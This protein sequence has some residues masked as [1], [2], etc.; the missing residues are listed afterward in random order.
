[1]LERPESLRTSSDLMCVVQL[2]YTNPHKGNLFRHSVSEKERVIAREVLGRSVKKHGSLE[3]ALARIKGTPTMHAVES[4]DTVALG[5][6][7]SSALLLGRGDGTVEAIDV[8]T[9]MPL[10]RTRLHSGRVAKISLN[11]EGRRTVTTS[12]DGSIALWRLN[13]AG[14]A[15]EARLYA[16]PDGEWL[17]ITPAGFFA[18]SSFG[19]HHINVVQGLKAIS[20]AQ[21]FD[22]LYRP[23]LVEELLKGDLEGKYKDAA[24]QLNLDAVLASGPSPQIEHLSDLDDRAGDSIRLSLRITGRGGGVGK[25]IIWKVNGVAQGNTTPPA[26]AGLDGPL[27]SVV[28]TE[29]L[30]LVPGQVNDIEVTAYNGTRLVATPPFK[31]IVDKFGISTTER[32]R[33]FVLA[34]G[35]NKYRMKEYQ[36]SYAASDATSLAKALSMV[37]SSLFSKVTTKAL[38]DEQVSEAG[39]AGAIDQIARE[40]KPEDVF[41][42]FLGGHGKS[43]AGRYYCYPQTLDFA[44]GQAVEQHAIGQDK[45]EAWLA[46]I[47]VQKSLLVIDTCEGDAFRGSRGTDNA[48]QTAMAQLQ[49]ATGRNIIAASREAAYEGHQGHGVLTYAILEA[50]GKKASAD[51]DDRVRVTAL[52]DHIGM[53]VPEISRSSFGIIQN[54]T[55]KLTGNDFPI[56]IRQP[57]LTAAADSGP[58]ILKEPPHVLIRAELLRERPAT[59]APGS[60]ERAPGTQVRAVEFHG[61]W[62]IVARDGQKLGYVPVEALVRLQ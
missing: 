55:R 58:A 10:W 25:H 16:A 59:D 42:L 49:R 23:D 32:P 41:V 13:R 20:V 56:G 28:V 9:L 50:L 40:A 43:I 22:H 5:M 52:A 6:A 44:A 36:L 60:R 24:H 39:I 8:Q 2:L 37:G 19:S 30:K 38:I 17:T 45:W 3:K 47:L 21:V 46:R 29:T 18:G 31:I 62:V 33:M 7:G 4:Y 53:R 11:M 57:V 14:S 48:R 35:I 27:A 12:M 51:G 26:L 61:A 34:L 15:L 54:P 1:M